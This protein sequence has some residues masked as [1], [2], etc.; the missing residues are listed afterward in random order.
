MG[1]QPSSA[2]DDRGGGGLVAQPQSP[3]VLSA[4]GIS[5][6]FS[7]VYVLRDARLLLRRGR[8]HALMGEN[9]AGK[10]TFMNIL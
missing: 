10:S 2:R 7:G 1:G 3:I 9:G 6:A 4:D 8:I 5:K